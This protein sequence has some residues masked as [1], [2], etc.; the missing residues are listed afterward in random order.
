MAES[1]LS[2]LEKDLE[3]IIFETENKFLY[4]RGLYITGEKKRQLR[5]GNYGIA[6]IITFRKHN[7]WEE[8]EE[9][10]KLCITVYELK[11]KIINANTLMQ[12]FR[13]CKGIEQY[14]N[15]RNKNLSVMF[16]VVLIG[17][18]L[19][20]GDFCYLPDYIDNLSMY[21][22]DYGFDGIKFKYQDS[23]RLTEEGF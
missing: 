20:D 1:K 10:S 2:F 4:E 7:F 11:Q 22:Y 12:A 14:I 13:Y 19:S 6:D 17:K 8:G 21:T 23:Y 18:E 9:E 15:H 3:T 5:I 16:K